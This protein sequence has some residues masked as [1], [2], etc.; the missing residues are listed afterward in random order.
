MKILQ[1]IKMK[2]T[3]RV[4]GYLYRLLPDGMLQYVSFASSVDSIEA[5]KVKPATQ[6][7][8]EAAKKA[9]REAGLRG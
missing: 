6:A 4:I 7:E 5:H 8:L 3:G 9:Q 2:S 1:P